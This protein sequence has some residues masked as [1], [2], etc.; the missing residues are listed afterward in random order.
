[1]TLDQ[2]PVEELMGKT[3][4]VLVEFPGRI[5]IGTMGT[6]TEI[7]QQGSVVVSWFDTGGDGS[8]MIGVQDGF[9]RDNEQRWLE[10]LDEEAQT[11]LNIKHKTE[12]EIALGKKIW[13]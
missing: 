7:Y 3:V 13:S 10:V 1:M 8:D 12:I 6:V 4:R 9:A 2:V 11:Q 5:P